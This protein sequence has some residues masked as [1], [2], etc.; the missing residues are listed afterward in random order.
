MDRRMFKPYSSSDYE[1]LH[2][3]CKFCSPGFVNHRVRKITVSSGILSVGDA[4]NLGSFLPFND[5]SRLLFSLA[6]V[7]A[8]Q[9]LDG[10]VSV[11]ECQ[12]WMVLPS[13]PVCLF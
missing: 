12:C 7:R 4:S 6:S 1:Q 5:L 3:S 10:A 8:S 9:Y 2:V 13:D 11:Y